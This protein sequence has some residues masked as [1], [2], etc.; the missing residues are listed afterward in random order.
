MDFDLKLDQLDQE[1]KELKDSEEYKILAEKNRASTPTEQDIGEWQILKE[2]LDELNGERHNYV[3]LI[4]FTNS[5][6]AKKSE[7]ARKERKKEIAINDERLFLSTVAIK[8]RERFQFYCDFEN[9]PMFEDVKRATGF[10]CED[11]VRDYFQKKARG[12]I[13]EEDDIKEAFSEDAWIWLIELDYRVN[14][15]FRDTLVENEDGSLRVVLE[16]EFYQDG[17]KE[18]VENLIL[19]VYGKK[20]DVHQAIN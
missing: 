9:S 16:E 6:A 20:A 8:L 4:M 7:K 3:K 2:K 1:I 18:L 5:H 15:P 10:K 11:D 13:T 12:E 14:G 19:K 17:G